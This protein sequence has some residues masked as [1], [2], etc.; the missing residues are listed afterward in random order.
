MDATTALPYRAYRPRPFTKAERPD[1]T[2]LFGG[3]HWRAERVLQAVFERQGYN[4]RVLPTANKADLLTGR[5]GGERYLAAASVSKRAGTSGRIR[6][7]C[8][9]IGT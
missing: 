2:I 6:P 9:N 3:L 7:K 5:S 4:A 8:Q 1:V